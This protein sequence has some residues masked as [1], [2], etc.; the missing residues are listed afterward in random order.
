MSLPGAIR[1]SFER[2]FD[3]YR[4]LAGALDADALTSDL[5]A[6]PSNTIGQQLWCVVGARESYA[7]AVR[8]GAWSGFSCSLRNPADRSAV[9]ESLARSETAVR[10]ALDALETY[11]SAQSRLIVDLLEHEA[12][13]HGQLIR[14]LYALRLAIPTS[15]KARYALD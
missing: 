14:Y 13:H 3:L 7:R 4:D 6:V 5:G 10:E 2:S 1:Q 8:A 11:T 12:A 9:A 15:W